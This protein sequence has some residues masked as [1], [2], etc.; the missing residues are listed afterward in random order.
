MQ[1]RVVYDTDQKVLRDI[2]DVLGNDLVSF[3]FVYFCLLLL[4][5]K[6]KYLVH[7]ERRFVKSGL[8][9][10][11][12]LKGD[13]MVYQFYLFND[14]LIYASEGHG[15]LNV[16]RVL[17]LSLCRIVDIKDGPIRNVKN[18]FRIISPQKAIFLF[19]E[20]TQE[21]REWFQAIQYAISEQI[22]F[23]TR[24]MNDMH[25]TAQISQFIGR[26]VGPK[27][28]LKRVQAG[29]QNMKSRNVSP[30]VKLEIAI[31][32]RQAPCKLCMRPF[33]RFTR[34]VN[35]KAMKQ[36]Q[37]NLLILKTK[38]YVNKKCVLQMK[39]PWCQHTVCAECFR[40]K[41]KIP[42]NEKPLKVCDGCFG[43]INYFIADI[44]HTDVEF[45]TTDASVLPAVDNSNWRR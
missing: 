4:H 31:F 2:E 22:E 23:R 1:K 42:T 25:P 3:F 35:S 29:E 30:S 14:L 17:H 44:N 7:P 24:W 6:K 18:G 8:L 43:A 26:T 45:S 36:K 11:Q 12:S 15:R 10:K 5:N 37:Y 9:T 19:A 38:N 40:R 16:H 34:K 13:L 21:K 32:Q 28:E 39:C 33:K 41:A 27:H 20:T